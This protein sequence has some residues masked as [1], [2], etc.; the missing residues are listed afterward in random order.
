MRLVGLMGLIGLMAL[1]VSCQGGGDE[2]GSV[3]IGRRAPVFSLKALDGSTVNSRSLE[4]NVVVLNFWATWCGPCVKEIPDLRQLAANSGVKVVG[5][6]LD[7]DGAKSVGPFVEMHG[8]NR[9]PN[10]IVALGDQETFDRF[11]G[12]SI[13]Y[14]LLLD[15][16]QR[17]IKVY[18]GP[19]TKEIL[20]QDL[21]EINVAFSKPSER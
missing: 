4:G 17:V 19:T 8:L 2:G 18:R 9:T 15:R 11:N 13:P 16:Q 7:E 10:Y 12:M 21:K 14:T 3:E 5:V 6:A 20:E 1:V